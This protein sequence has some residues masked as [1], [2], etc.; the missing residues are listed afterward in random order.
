MDATRGAL[1]GERCWLTHEEHDGEYDLCGVEGMN[2]F[3]ASLLLSQTTLEDLLEK[4][5]DDRLLQ[6]GAGG[7]DRIMRFNAEVARRLE[8]M[9]LPPSSPIYVDTSSSLNSVPYIGDS[10]MDAL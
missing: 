8:L 1:W 2:L 5:P 6:Y 7:V 10:E 4:H 9:Q 3:A